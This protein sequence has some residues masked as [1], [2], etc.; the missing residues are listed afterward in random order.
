MIGGVYL[1]VTRVLVF[2]YKVYTSDAPIL[3]FIYDDVVAVSHTIIRGCFCVRVSLNVE[4]CFALIF[5][6]IYLHI[7]AHMHINVY[8]ARIFMSLY[9]VLST[10]YICE[11]ASLSIKFYSLFNRAD[12]S[13]FTVY[14][15][16]Y[17][18]LFSYIC[19]CLIYTT[20]VCGAFECHCLCLC[21]AKHISVREVCCI[22][23]ATLHFHNFV[24][25]TKHLP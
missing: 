3:L 12:C 7:Q 10:K 16:V 23:S 1:C 9:T 25:M 20:R 13:L 24:K 4:M 17:P 14:A 2:K 11:F 22:L 5:E 21:I 8:V 18:M 6:F 15:A 19:M